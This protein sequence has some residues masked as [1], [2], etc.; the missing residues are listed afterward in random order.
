MKNKYM[1]FMAK[2]YMHIFDDLAVKIHLL[3]I[4]TY[5]LYIYS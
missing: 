1:H 4:Y 3:K 2:F 5:T